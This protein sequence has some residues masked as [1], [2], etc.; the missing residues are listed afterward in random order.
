MFFFYSMHSPNFPPQN[1]V[2][3]LPTMQLDQQLKQF[4]PSGAT[5]GFIQLASHT[6]CN[7]GSLDL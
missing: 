1:L 3:V 4:A 7:N 5:E 2:P 6:V